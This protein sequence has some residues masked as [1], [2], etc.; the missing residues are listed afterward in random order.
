VKSALHPIRPVTVLAAVALAASL[1]TGCSAVSAVIKAQSHAE[2]CA[3]I[4]VQLKGIGTAMSAKMA[5][6]KTNPTAAASDV[7]KDTAKFSTA[8]GKLT[9]PAVKKAATSAAHQ[10][11]TFS[12]DLTTLTQTESAASASKIEADLPKLQVALGAVESA[13]KV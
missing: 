10:L 11:S 3:R 13:C 8:A 9:N 12:D 2:A 7:A 1:L 5:E 4:A 6:L